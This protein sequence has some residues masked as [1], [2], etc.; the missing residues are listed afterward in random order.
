MI[1]ID[2]ICISLIIFNFHYC[3]EDTNTY[4]NV[5]TWG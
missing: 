4:C 3:I 2:I 1:I 5:L